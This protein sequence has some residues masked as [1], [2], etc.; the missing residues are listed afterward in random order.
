MGY[1][2]YVEVMFFLESDGRDENY[3]PKKLHSRHAGQMLPAGSI[4][5]AI[6]DLNQEEI[7]YFYNDVPKEKVIDFILESIR[8]NPEYYQ[9]EG[10]QALK[11][12]DFKILGVER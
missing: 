4:P 2:N 1:Y 3:V 7:Y 8:N 12:E 10:M 9:Y 6:C 11:R 5:L